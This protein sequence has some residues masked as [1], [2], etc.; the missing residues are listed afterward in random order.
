[1]WKLTRPDNRH[2]KLVRDTLLDLQNHHLVRIETVQE[3]QRQVW[4]LTR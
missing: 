4:V 2:D 3:D 1:M